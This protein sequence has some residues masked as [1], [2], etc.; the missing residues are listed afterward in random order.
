V[1]REQQKNAGRAGTRTWAPAGGVAAA[2]RAVD[3]ARAR[4]ARE[5]I[6]ARARR[7]FATKLSS[8]RSIEMMRCDNDNDDAGSS[9]CS[10][11]EFVLFSKDESAS[12]LMLMIRC[13]FSAAC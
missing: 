13:R 4:L 2:Y 8:S 5:S 11:G 12:M 1:T 9:S 3:G 10:S 7:V 6:G